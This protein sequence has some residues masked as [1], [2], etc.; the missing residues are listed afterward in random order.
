MPLDEETE[1][2]FDLLKRLLHAIGICARRDK[3]GY[4]LVDKFGN[5]LELYDLKSDVE[6]ENL[7]FTPK[8]LVDALIGEKRA[9][10]FKVWITGERIKNPFFKC[11]CKE[12][13]RIL[14]DLLS[15][16]RDHQRRKS[17]S[18]GQ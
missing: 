12:E 13:V 5:M 11:Q 14:L 1:D 2:S 18:G 7:F 4:R 9:S 10:E 6:T 15:G 17:F 16:S 8:Q 3:N